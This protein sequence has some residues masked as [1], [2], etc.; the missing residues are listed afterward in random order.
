MA[1]TRSMSIAEAAAHISRGNDPWGDH[2]GVRADVSYGFVQSGFAFSEEQARVTH[3]VMN[4]WADVAQINFFFD[5]DPDIHFENF[6]D[7]DDPGVGYT[8]VDR[9]FPNVLPEFIDQSVTVGFN[10]AL[11][12]GT[13]SLQQGGDDRNTLIHEIGHAL[14]L[15]HPGNYNAEEGK[16]PATYEANADHIEDTAK[17]SVMSYFSE[18]YTDANHGVEWARTPLMHDIAAIQRLYGANMST[19]TDW[20]TYGFNSNA[21]DVYSIVNGDEDVVYCIWDA[22]GI[23]TLDLSGYDYEQV[24]NLAPGSFSDAGSLFGNIS[25]ADAVDIHGNNSWEPGFDANNIANYIENAIGG[26][27]KDTI[28]GNKTHNF[29][30]GR[31]GDDVILGWEGN[32]TLWGGIGNDRLYGG[33]DIDTL[34]GFTGND[35]LVGDEGTDTLYGEDGDDILYAGDHLKGDEAVDKLYGGNGNDSYYVT[36]RFDQVFEFGTGETDRIF[37]NL[38]VLSLADTNVVQGDVEHLVFVGTGS[39]KGIGNAL[40]NALVGGTANDDLRGGDGHDWID[41]AGGQDTMY[42]GTGYDTYT[43]DNAGDKIIEIEAESNGAVVDNSLDTIRTKLAIYSMNTPN[44]VGNVENLEYFGT[45]SFNGTG[46]ALA[47]TIKGGVNGDTLSGLGGDDRLEGGGGIDTLRGGADND[48]LDGGASRDNMYGGTGDDTYIVD[49]SLDKVIEAEAELASVPNGNSGVDGGIDTVM[50]EL[51]TFGLNSFTVTGKVENLTYTGSGTFNGTGNALHNVIK[52]GAQS[53]KLFGLAGSDTLEGGGGNDTLEGGADADTLL[54]GTGEDTFKYTHAADAAGDTIYGG[55]PGF[56]TS[57]DILDFSVL[58][59]TVSVDLSAKRF[60]ATET[61][62]A[63]RIV[64]TV[65]ASSGEINGIEQVIGTNNAD[66]LIGNA[67]GNILDGGAGNDILEGGAGNDILNGGGGQDTFVYA[68]GWNRDA[69]ADFRSGEDIIDMRRVTGLTSFDQ[70]VTEDTY[71]GVRIWVQGNA[72]HTIGLVGVFKADLSASDFLIAGQADPRAAMVG[73]EGTDY[74]TGNNFANDIDALG[75]ADVIDGGNG[76]DNIR[77][78]AGNDLIKV[79]GTM[80]AGLDKIDGGADIDTLDASGFAGHVTVNLVNGSYGLSAMDGSSW[81]VG[82]ALITGVENLTGGAGNDRFTGDAKANYLKGGLG[83]DTLLGG[84]GNDILEAQGGR[85]TLDGGAGDDYLFVSK[86]TL[87]AVGG[88]GW[89]G[90]IADETTIADGF[91]FRLLGAAVE[92]VAGNAGNDVIDGRGLATAMTLS[93]G[94]GNDTLYGGNGQTTFWAGDGDDVMLGGN[95]LDQFVGGAGNDVMT[96]GRGADR[97]D[98]GDGDDILNVDNADTLI[99]GGNGYDIVYADATTTAGFRFAIGSSGVEKVYGNTGADVIDASGAASSGEDFRQ[100]YTGAGNDRVIAGS[101]SYD[102][103]VGGQGTDTAVF[104]GARADYTIVAEHAS[105]YSGWTLVYNNSTGAMDWLMSVE[106][107]QFSDQT[108][109]AD[110]V[111]SVI[112]GTAAGDVR[113]GTAVSEEMYG[114]AGNDRLNGGGGDDILDGGAG[115]DQLLGGDGDDVL[116][117]DGLDTF[118]GG[119]GVDQVYVDEARGALGLS[120]DLAEHN[121]EIVYGGSRNDRFDGGSSAS[122][123]ELNGLGGDDVLIGSSVAHSSLLGG[124]GHDV[125]IGGASADYLTGESGN[126]DLTGGAG[127][128]SFYFADGF[129]RDVIRD[130]ESGV[131]RIEMTGVSGLDNFSQLSIAAGELG[132]EI[133]FAGQTIV[134]QGVDAALV[135][136]SDFIL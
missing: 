74:I 75:G 1:P 44:V 61:I 134:L 53:D 29:I 119:A 63:G 84:G 56:D 103:I 120:F 107:M 62:K 79:S 108:V 96:G 65:G 35:T 86:D 33:R 24:I 112:S 106:R 72:D 22:G 98:G 78:G 17:Y 28:H 132:A 69:I 7:E 90:V 88:A 51:G 38:R 126:D 13:D 11:D 25:M 101:G 118:D 9:L 91:K 42:G 52:G 121:V 99:S 66:T 97:L 131:D 110:L 116:F 89:D 57:I 16:P 3:Q 10:R 12:W 32:D 125:L 55:V 31:S 39:F 4:L 14:G 47:N 27:G 82:A 130:F 94:A 48:T 109:N 54:G 115:A 80:A 93:G 70:L 67:T 95:A 23:D 8:A 45:A 133:S 59:G 60:S 129:G 135:S 34:Y 104:A 43:V 50:T 87:K 40:N 128:D 36:D 46:N 122:S 102:W 26:T 58:N 6:R 5:P 117:I 76:K 111:R 37:T 114:L 85:D 92:Y 73:T 127:A 77:A 19:R 83:D 2:F 49:S 21:G 100:I 68:D 136:A 18:T 113:T 64:T 30:D 71:Q 20:T 124:T 41:G 123:V 15:S 81:A 105:G